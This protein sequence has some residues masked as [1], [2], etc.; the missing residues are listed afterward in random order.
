MKKKWKLTAVLFLIIILIAGALIYSNYS[1]K[2][3]EKG[4]KADTI[5]LKSV[6]KQGE[7]ISN[8][9]KITNLKE[10]Q[11]F[12]ISIRD[13]KSF[14]SL[15]EDE[16]ELDKDESKNIEVGFKGYSYP[17]DVYVGS[18]VIEADSRKEIIPV[19]LE[20][21]SKEVS[22]A[23]NLNIPASSK[24]I[25]PGEQVIIGVKIFNLLDTKPHTVKLS[26]SIKNLEGENI[27]LESENVVVTTEN[28]L[29]KNILIP[30]NINLGDYAF[31]LTIGF[32]D[33]L[34]TSSYLFSVVEKESVFSNLGG[35]GVTI[36]FA[37][38]VL[39]FVLGIVILF[40]Y[41]MKE[42]DRLFMQLKKQQTNELRSALE[43]IK[44]RKQAVVVIAKPAEK[45]KIERK[46][47][48]ARKKA[49]KKIKEK[50]RVQRV[51]FKQLKKKKRTSEMKKKIDEWKK[52]G[53]NVDE[54]L[55]KTGKIKTG[56]NINKLKKAGYDISALK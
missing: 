23:A 41:M 22:F 27:F 42:R 17:P 1:K 19:I 32:E 20:I 37:V 35:S 44:Q 6:I 14:V 26:Y 45:K 4:F 29:I 30:E 38:I 53:F 34:S 12:K 3:T 28:Q 50:H 33:S 10:K 13:L 16:F 24:Q 11:N 31:T 46:F 47:K 36:I 39:G 18:L 48:E 21:Q 5:I 15:S 9:F 51:V 8:N 56:M 52:Q 25:T 43:K 54:F 7:V 55:I 2:S 49:V 40:I